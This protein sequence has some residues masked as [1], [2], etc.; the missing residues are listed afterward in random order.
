VQTV[1]DPSTMII[2][3]TYPIITAE[4]ALFM[5]TERRKAID[6]EHI[7]HAEY[8]SKTTPKCVSVKTLMPVAN[9]PKSR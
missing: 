7:P 2:E 5:K 4:V 3:N 9:L 1:D 8:A 6:T